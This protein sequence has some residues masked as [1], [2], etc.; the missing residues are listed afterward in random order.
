MTKSRLGMACID[1]R[2][3][4]DY[5]LD[6]TKSTNHKSIQRQRTPAQA[7]NNKHHY[8]M[9]NTRKPHLTGI[10]EFGTAA[11]FKDLTPGKLDARVT[12]GRCMG[13][14]S[15][16]AIVHGEAQSEG[17]RDE[18][19]QASQKNVDIEEPETEPEKDQPQQHLPSENDSETHQSQEPTEEDNVLP[20][21]ETPDNDPSFNPEYGR[22]KG[23][24]HPKRGR[25]RGITPLKFTNLETAVT[26][27][28]SA[29][30]KPTSGKR[31]ALSLSAL[32][33]L[34]RHFHFWSTFRHFHFRHFHFWLNTFT[35]GALFDS[36]TFGTCTFGSTLSLLEHFSTLSLFKPQ[37]F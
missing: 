10:Q 4:K 20:D 32:A 8:K 33:L 34:A 21:L 18:T 12:R 14:E 24:R 27:V 7:L 22:R 37:I 35:F 29:F 26:T 6:R 11:H 1:S 16:S 31:Q 23:T 25:P 30:R 9:C 13:Y 2:T 15:K 3:S 5:R 19:I 28:D 36:F 17:E